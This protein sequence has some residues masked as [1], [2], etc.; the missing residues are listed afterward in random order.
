MVAIGLLERYVA[1][2]GEAFG[3]T[4]NELLLLKLFCSG[5]SLVFESA[6]H[7]GGEL[8]QRSVPP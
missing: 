2:L 8:S 7:L 4:E 3:P 1:F 6:P 5:S